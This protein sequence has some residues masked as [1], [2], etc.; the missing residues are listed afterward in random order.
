MKKTLSI[1]LGTLLFLACIGSGWVLY[2]L[3]TDSRAFTSVQHPEL[4][5][6]ALPNAVLPLEKAQN[7]EAAGELLPIPSAR[8]SRPMLHRLPPKPQLTVPELQCGPP[9]P[10]EQGSGSVRHCEPVR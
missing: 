6:D 2:R 8:P 1:A 4:Q 7:I 5:V 9:R 3:T 10:L